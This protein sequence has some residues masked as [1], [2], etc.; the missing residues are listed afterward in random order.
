MYT[1]P[2][3]VTVCTL[4]HSM[5]RCLHWPTACH[6]VY[7]GP[8]H[9][10]VSKLSLGVTRFL[11]AYTARG[12]DTLP[13]TCLQLTFVYQPSK[14]Q[15]RPWFSMDTTV[16]EAQPRPS[17]I[18]HHLRC[19]MMKYCIISSLRCTVSVSLILGVRMSSTCKSKC[20]RSRLA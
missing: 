9:V 14:C 4:A 3:H 6:G 10:T 16:R 8:Q 2:Q 1:G 19:R 7:T 13:P 5:S 18:L 12:R 15:T 20:F 11:V 17:T